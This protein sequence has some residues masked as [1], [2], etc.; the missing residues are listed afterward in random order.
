[1]TAICKHGQ[2]YRSCERCE[3]ERELAALR[4]LL[5]TKEAE[6]AAKSAELERALEDKEASRHSLA[7][8]IHETLKV[9]GFFSPGCDR[10]S[11]LIGA[12]ARALDAGKEE[13]K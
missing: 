3:L 6:L 8:E 13:G 2:L 7:Q 4:V 5:A 12:V 9:R 10:A 11:D 1:M